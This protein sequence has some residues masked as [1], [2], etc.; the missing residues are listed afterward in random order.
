MNSR[1]PSS[2]VRFQSFILKE[3]CKDGGTRMLLTI[4]DLTN[5]MLKLDPKDDLN[6]TRKQ[7]GNLEK[8][9]K[10]FKTPIFILDAMVVKLSSPEAMETFHRDGVITDD[11]YKL[12]LETLEINKVKNAETDRIMARFRGEEVNHIYSL[13][14][15]I[16]F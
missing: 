11:A 16:L 5:K 12:Y 6:L 8:C 9:L 3:I 10:S 13:E 14:V 7:F 1:I 4:S 2:Q 15:L